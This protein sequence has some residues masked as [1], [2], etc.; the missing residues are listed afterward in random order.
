MLFGFNLLHSIPGT[1]LI[2]NENIIPLLVKPP[3]DDEAP[4]K[5]PISMGRPFWVDIQLFS[6]EIGI[7]IRRNNTDGL[8]LVS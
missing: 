7:I 8:S 1:A 2:S 5:S 3:V 6:H 4:E